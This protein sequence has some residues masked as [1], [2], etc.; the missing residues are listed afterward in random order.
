M[1]AEPQSIAPAT[2]RAPL[3]FSR[4]AEVVED[5]DNR[6]L[7]RAVTRPLDGDFEA[8]FE[9]RECTLKDWSL[10]GRD[11]LDLL[12]MGFEAIDLSPHAELQQLLAGIRAAAEISPAEAKQLRRLLTGRVFPLSGGKCLKFLNVAPEGPI[13]R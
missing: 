3:G 2:V 6:G 1:A 12:T 8:Q 4:P 7:R 11:T 13:M 5:Y 9:L 10:R